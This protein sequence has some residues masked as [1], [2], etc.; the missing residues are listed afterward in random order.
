VSQRRN[1]SKALRRSNF[2][3]RVVQRKNGTAGHIYQRKPDAN[4]RN[5]L[6]RIAS[7]SPLAFSAG[8][9]LLRESAGLNANSKLEA[10]PFYPISDEQGAKAACYAL[11]S[12]GLTDVERLIRSAAN[13]RQADPNEASWWLGRLMRDSESR[14]LRALRILSEAVK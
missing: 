11:I 4:G 3:L 13:F 10:G 2:A 1:R 7:L 9:S 8:L 12:S 5:R 6:Q 14:S